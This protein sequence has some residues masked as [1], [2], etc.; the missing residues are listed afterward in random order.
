MK[1]I[2]KDHQRTLKR[3]IMGG[4]LKDNFDYVFN[5]EKD[6]FQSYLLPN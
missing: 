6:D 3:L 4:Q 1:M 5:G 2:E